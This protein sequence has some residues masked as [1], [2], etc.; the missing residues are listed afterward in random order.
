M[1]AGALMAIAF[2]LLLFF[3]LSPSSAAAPDLVRFVGRFH[4]LAVHLP[5]GVLVLIATAEVLML[6]PW[7]RERIDFALGLALPFLVAS[8]VVAFSLG[9]LLAHGGGYPVKLVRLHRAL[10]L[11]GVIGSAVSMIAWSMQQHDR[12]RSRR[13]TYRLALGTTVAIVSLGAH[14]GGSM[15]HGEAY[16]TRFAPAFLRGHLESGPATQPVA[17]AVAVAEDEPRV[18][19]DVVQPVLASH[20]L[21]CHGADAAQGGLRLDSFAGMMKGGDD[22]AAIIVGSG[23]ESPL[24]RRMT[25]DVTDDGHMPPDGRHGPT[26]NEIA[27][28]RWWIDRGAT[29][30]LRVRDGVVPVAARAILEDAGAR[31]DATSGRA[32]HSSSRGAVPE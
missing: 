1:V 13:L 19:R 32:G 17:A 12:A 8:M 31:S 9:I 27:L 10:S 2:A 30:S 3:A 25:L 21:E 26:P 6:F 23:G 7:L 22:G 14:F 15:T 5:L 18:F 24:V 20:C 11:A 28:I 4:A 29:E 16:L